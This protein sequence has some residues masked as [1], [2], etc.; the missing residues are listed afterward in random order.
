MGFLAS[1][2]KVGRLFGI[3]IRVHVLFVIYIAWRL[4]QGAG[5]GSMATSAAFLAMLFGIV[6]IHEFG[7]CL[8]ARAVG[9]DAENI[10]MWPLGGL[11]FAHAP[12]RPWPQFVTVAAGPMV[13]VIFCIISAITIYVL[14]QGQLLPGINPVS[15]TVHF[16]GSNPAAIAQMPHWVNYVLLFYWVNLFILAFNLLPIFPFDG[17]QLLHAIIWPFLGLQR[18]SIVACYI[19]LTGCFF[20]GVWG[21]MQQIMI[22]PFIAVFGGMA[23]YQRLQAA[24]YGL[25]YEDPA[26]TPVYNPRAQHSSF[27]GRLFRGRH[28]HSSPTTPTPNPNPGAWDE[29]QR[30]QRESEEELDRLLQK[31]SEQGIQSLTY[32][33]RQRLEHITRERQKEED[34]YE[35]N[36][37]L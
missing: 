28:H 21:L 19:G 29:R 16:V 2:F 7:H 25:L 11:A 15:Q 35:K 8:G 10:L 37:T 36:R 17:G 6:L 26:Y 14:S 13:N 12:M 27:W 23:C 32:T 34:R 22:L 1:S 18:A 20:L 24:R 3:N 5:Q 31:V 4:F 33:E 30:R 9:G